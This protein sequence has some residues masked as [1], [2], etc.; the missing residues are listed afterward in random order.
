MIYQMI[1]LVIDVISNISNGF[2]VYLKSVDLFNSMLFC[3]KG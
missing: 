3:T 2:D 1:Y